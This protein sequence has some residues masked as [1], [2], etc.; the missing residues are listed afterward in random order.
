MLVM[1][2]L[3]AAPSAGSTCFIRN[4]RTYLYTIS[5]TFKA[6]TINKYK[7]PSAPPPLELPKLS[8]C[9]KLI[10]VTQIIYIK[11]SVDYSQCKQFQDK[12]VKEVKKFKEVMPYQALEAYSYYRHY[13]NKTEEEVKVRKECRRDKP[14]ARWERDIKRL[15]GLNL[16]VLLDLKRLN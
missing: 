13:Y 14:Y 8:Q 15:K 2:T 16:K 5:V 7:K 12:E 3:S 6:F 10:K 9:T 1:L 4:T 11:L